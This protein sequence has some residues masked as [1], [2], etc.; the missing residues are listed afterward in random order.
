[1]SLYRCCFWERIQN[2][3][4]MQSVARENDAEAVAWLD[5]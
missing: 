4:Q 3:F 1:M 5:A 2:T